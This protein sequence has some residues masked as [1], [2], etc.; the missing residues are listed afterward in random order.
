MQLGCLF[1]TLDM[2][3]SYAGTRV[4][5]G[6]PIGGFQAIKHRC[7]DVF[8]D[9]E[10]TRWVVY[11]AAALA[12]DPETTAEGLDEAA[13]MTSAYAAS[14]SF[15]GVANLLQVLG[16]IGYTWEHQ[17]HLYFKRATAAARLLGSSSY[18]LDAVSRAIDEAPQ[19]SA[20]MGSL[21]TA[22]PLR[23]G[24]VGLGAARG[25]AASAHVPAIR[26]VDGVELAG[27]CGSTPESSRRGA[28]AHGLDRAYETPE[29]L[30]ASDDIDLVVIT[31]KVSRHLSLV[32]TALDAGKAVLCEWPLGNG[33]DEAEDLARRAAERGVRNIVGLQVLSAPFL[34]HLVDVV[35]R[36]D[37]GE[38]LSTSMIASGS[39]WGATLREDR[40]L[41]DPAVGATMLTIPMGHTLAGVEAVLGRLVS[42][43]ATTA[44]RRPTATEL[45]SGTV[46][47]R[48]TPDQTVVTGILE[49][50][51]P[52]VP[53]Y[54][55]GTSKATNFH[56]EINGSLGDIVVTGRNGHMQQ[57]F[58]QVSMAGKDREPCSRWPPPRLRAG[59]WD[60][61]NE[62]GLHHRAQL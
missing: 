58:A 44:I 43:Q 19:P 33:L 25:W 8:M 56:W 26:A 41:M 30:A 22:A 11:H 16:G 21:V 59:A 1:A 45:P 12:S 51:A 52:A 62:P 46:H 6:R 54:R 7:A 20:W 39:A 55:G 28:E 15:R 38:V 60:P 36:G 29:A 24:I 57:G 5:F 17:G 31:V 2:A 50:G 9:T 13:H 35:E 61:R 48:G 49:S 27:A 10:T 53:H 4:Q 23:V 37:I 32:T 40:Y 34:R 18:H 3:V 42:V 14:S 47:R